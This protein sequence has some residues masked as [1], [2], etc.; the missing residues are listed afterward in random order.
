[1]YVDSWSSAEGEALERLEGAL[2]PGE[3]Y[4]GWEDDTMTQ[5]IADLGRTIDRDAR[6]DIYKEVQRYMYDNPMFVYLYAPVAFEA[7][8]TSVEGYQP[9]PNEGYSLD[10]VTVN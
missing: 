3:F 6:A 9:G 10:N 4:A 8:S 2:N 5:L 1:M 7:V